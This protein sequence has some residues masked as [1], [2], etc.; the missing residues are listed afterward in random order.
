MNRRLILWGSVVI[1]AGCV[2]YFAVPSDESERN[3]S[4]V[5]EVE[6]RPTSAV[7]ARDAG[8]A[9]TDEPT[10]NG[11]DSARRDDALFALP[12]DAESWRRA[13]ESYSQADDDAYL[14]RRHN[15][16]AAAKHSQAIEAA[17]VSADDRRRLKDL[18]MSKELA[19]IDLSIAAKKSGLPRRGP[20]FEALVQA[21]RARID[22][23]IVALVGPTYFAEM[24]TM[25]GVGGIRLLGFHLM[26]EAYIRG[27]PLSD[28]QIEKINRVISTIGDE[29]QGLPVDPETG[30]NTFDATFLEGAKAALSTEQWGIF[31][32]LR[33]EENLHEAAMELK[34]QRRAQQK[35]QQEAAKT[36]K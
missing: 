2:I 6:K 29:P 7:Q 11:G 18:L 28:S 20:E 14:E 19:E 33:I 27:V 10:R 31:R 17:P 12:T 3:E 23:Q 4:Q 9:I 15:S 8:D 22:Q 21:E 30:L 5:R 25:P 1:L 36:A 32:R 24:Q 35:A 34:K 16:F 13:V 26:G